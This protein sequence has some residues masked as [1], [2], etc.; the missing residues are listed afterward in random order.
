MLVFQ[1]YVLQDDSLEQCQVN[2][3]DM[4]VYPELVRK[5]PGQGPGS[6]ILYRAGLNG[7]VKHRQRE[8]NDHERYKQKFPPFFNNFAFLQKY[9]KTAQIFCRTI[10]EPKIK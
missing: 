7:Q 3:P 4:D 2:A 8:K 1:P 5:I 9:T 6:K 10:K